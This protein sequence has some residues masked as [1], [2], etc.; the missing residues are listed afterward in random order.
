LGIEPLA[1]ATARTAR[2]RPRRRHRIA[3]TLSAAAFTAA[4]FTAAACFCTHRPGAGIS[5]W[6]AREC[7]AAPSS[8]VRSASFSTA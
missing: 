7:I 4:A 2:R 6:R 1:P 8:P 5:P 3:A